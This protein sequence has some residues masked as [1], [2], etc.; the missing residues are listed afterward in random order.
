MFSFTDFTAESDLD[1]L[2]S[3]L[4]E[5][6]V[7]VLPE[8]FK[9]DECDEFRNKVWSKLCQKHDI[10]NIK[11]YMAK[12]NPIHGG[13]IHSNGVSLYSEVL[14]LKTDERAIEP[15]R[16]IWNEKELT[17]SL[18]GLYIGPP[19]EQT[20]YFFNPDRLIHGE[21][22]HTDQASTK[23]T[24]CC[25]QSFITLESIESGDGCLSV[26]TNSHKYHAEFFELFNLKVNFDWFVLSEKHLKWFIEEKKCK[27]NTIL[28]PKGSMI[29]WDSRTM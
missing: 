8:V 10:K 13:L 6:G 20:G 26:L 22:F 25:V 9:K 15:F 21:S 28:A 27:W 19:A 23:K 12:I 24:K 2:Q 4:D 16:R 1:D 17:V 14:D 29:F 7:A 11:D 5:Y 3:K 18:D